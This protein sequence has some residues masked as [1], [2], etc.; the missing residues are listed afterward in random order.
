MA[1]TTED[2]K[3]FTIALTADEV[4]EPAKIPVAVLVGTA[5]IGLY[6]LLRRL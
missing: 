1:E 5:A 3:A 2:I 4:T 6:L